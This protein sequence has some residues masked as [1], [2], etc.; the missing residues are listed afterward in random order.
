MLVKTFSRL[1]T[2][3]EKIVSYN[4]GMLNSFWS[5]DR[6]AHTLVMSGSERVTESGDA[7]VW[8][9]EVKDT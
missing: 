2:F 7:T 9:E 3:K 5:W 1:K 8:Y 6:I 4:L